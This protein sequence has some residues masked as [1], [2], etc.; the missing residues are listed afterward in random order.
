MTDK[1]YIFSE[2]DSAHALNFLKTQTSKNSY[3]E[4]NRILGYLRTFKCNSKSVFSPGRDRHTR[5][6]RVKTWTRHVDIFTKDFL[7][8]PVNQE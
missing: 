1:V 6:Q 7:F 2:N 5:H 4:L 3:Y 8:V